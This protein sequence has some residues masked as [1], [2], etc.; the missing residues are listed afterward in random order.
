MLQYFVQLKSNESCGR[1]HDPN[2]DTVMK[3]IYDY[4]ENHSDCQF[5]FKE[6][7]SVAANDSGSLPSE[8]TIKNKLSEHYKNDII[9]A[10]NKKHETTVCFKNVGCKI[11]GDSWYSEKCKDENDEKFRII[12]KAAEIIK[13]DIADKIY[14]NQSYPNSIV[15]LDN[16]VEQVSNTLSFLL[17]NIVAKG[18]KP[19]T[20]TTTKK[21]TTIAHMIISEV[22]PRSFISPIKLG[23]AAFIFKKIGSKTL[24]DVLSSLGICSSYS[25]VKVLETSLVVAPPEVIKPGGFVQYVFDNCDF[26]VSNLDGFN[27]FHNMAGI[28]CITPKENVINEL[29]EIKKVNRLKQSQL[30]DK[31]GVVNATVYEDQGQSGLSK[32]KFKNLNNIYD[33]KHYNETPLSYDV[34]WFIGQ[35]F[36][37][38]KIP[39]WQGFME[40]ITQKNFSNAS[41]I[42]YTPFVMS[43]PSDLDTINT[44]LRMALEDAEKLNLK[45]V[46][47]TFDLPLYMKAIDIILSAPHDSSLKKIVVRLGGFHLLMSFLGSIGFIMADS[48]LKEI[49]CTIYAENSVDHILTG[50]AYARAVRAHLLV[51]L[52]LS[53]VILKNAQFSEEEKNFVN[54]TFENVTEKN[55]DFMSKSEIEDNILVKNMAQKFE[56]ELKKK[57]KKGDTAK[58]WL[59][60]FNMVTLVKNF[61]EAER[62][63]NWEKHLYTIKLMMPYFYASGHHHY[64]KACHI[65]L[66][67]MSSLEEKMDIFEY[68][69]FTKDG[70]F[71]IRRSE[72]FFSGTWTDMVIEQTANRDFKV[73]GG[74]VQRSFTDNVLSAHVITKFSLSNICVALEDYCDTHF[75]TSE[76]H[77]ELRESRIYKNNIDVKKLVEW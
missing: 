14:N 6:L 3:I 12:K 50:H 21:C 1:P 56:N 60:Y 16:V 4:M 17:E 53:K 35:F 7:I 58:Y 22:K 77:I 72:K 8:R 47:V 75:A 44:C 65:Y 46:F 52:A 51:Q 71:T 32:Y 26:N 29:V 38:N 20:V 30:L 40:K 63:G 28:K 23:V 31:K 45:T 55:S 36:E 49:L 61:I 33:L 5:S 59:Q 48:G 37:C 62:T 68:L 34:L 67:E 69:K 19:L 70:Y 18:K 73:Q 41:K 25:D 76:Q 11:L 15:F 39:G 27:T 10:P 24:I 54:K 64:S 2:I 74:I 13:S 57:E 66:Q 42:L 43:P 9:I